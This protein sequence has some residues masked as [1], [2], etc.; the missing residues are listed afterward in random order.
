[1]YLHDRECVGHRW[2]RAGYSSG[3]LSTL[4]GVSNAGGQLGDEPERESDD[5]VLDARIREY[6]GHVRPFRYAGWE[7]DECRKRDPS[8]RGTNP[9]GI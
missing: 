4:T 3:V 5:P 1:M 8:F 9:G 7:R 6:C 2:K